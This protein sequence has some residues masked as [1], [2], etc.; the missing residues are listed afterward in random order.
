M[1]IL[2]FNLCTERRFGAVRLFKDPAGWVP[3][4]TKRGCSRR[5]SRNAWGITPR[6]WEVSPETDP[7]CLSHLGCVRGPD[8]FGVGDPSHKRV[9]TWA[10]RARFGRP[11]SRDGWCGRWGRG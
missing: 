11:E 1:A 10:V 2:R 8:A 5:T 9:L 4:Y 6:L 3:R 7:G